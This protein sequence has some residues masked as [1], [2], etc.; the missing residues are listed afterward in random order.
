MPHKISKVS[1]K[2]HRVSLT[3]VCHKSTRP[4]RECRT[5]VPHKSALQEWSKRVASH[6]RV[7]HEGVPQELS[8]R[9][10]H[11]S[12]HKSVFY[13]SVVVQNLP[14]VKRVPHQTVRLCHRSGLQECHKS[15][16]QVRHTSVPQECLLQ[17]CP[18]R[19]S[20]KSV[21]YKSVK[22]CLA[23]LFSIT[24]VHWGS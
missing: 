12:S 1:H 8:T 23:V 14:C 5:R 2:S 3:R 22:Q 16:P 20:H 15:V 13:K 4:T 19:V 7:S 18:T 11:G 17:E 9:V 24:G 21:S 10:S 6:K